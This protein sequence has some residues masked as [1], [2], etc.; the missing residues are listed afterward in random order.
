MVPRSNIKN[1]ASEVYAQKG[2]S[3]RS[4]V[5]RS[6]RRGHRSA[7]G[8]EPKAGDVIDWRTTNSVGFDCWPYYETWT[9]DATNAVDDTTDDTID[10]AVRDYD[11][12]LRRLADG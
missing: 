7:W 11:D 3:E 12:L 4:S 1:Q 2:P 9:S 10:E 6:Y 5:D 8:S